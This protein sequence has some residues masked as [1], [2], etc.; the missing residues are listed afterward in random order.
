MSAVETL[1][2]AADMIRDENRWMR[3]NFHDLSTGRRCAYSALCQ[4]E[5]GYPLAAC[6]ALCAAM[7]SPV[8]GDEAPS[9][10]WRFN[11]NNSH[12]KVIELFDR[13]IA[14]ELER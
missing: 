1:R 10:V 12:R 13:A 2:K 6:E 4:A 9:K 3:G 5:R 8:R 14:L 7:G 11:D